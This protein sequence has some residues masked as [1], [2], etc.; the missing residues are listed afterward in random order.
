LDTNA[1][2]FGVGEAGTPS[3][4]FSFD[5]QLHPT[6]IEITSFMPPLK[7][8]GAPG[9]LSGKITDTSTNT[10]QASTPVDGLVIETRG[11]GSDGLPFRV[12]SA[13]GG[14]VSFVGTTV[15]RTEP[16]PG[17]DAVMAFDGTVSYIRSSNTDTY[18]TIPHTSKLTL[19]NIL[20][21]NVETDVTLSGILEDTAFSSEPLP[22]QTISFGVVPEIGPGFTIDPVT[23]AFPITVTTLDNVD[24][25][26]V[27]SSNT[28]HLKEGDKLTLPL[29]A[30]RATLDIDDFGSSS[31]KVRIFWTCT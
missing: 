15:L 10:P 31:V 2:Y 26:F 20:D 4:S 21:V 1:D 23:T 5:S 22:G 19:D 7:P 27:D 6:D 8:W 29:S 9:T 28:L 25:V 12:E 13:G 18:I 16:S 3:A 11:T 14:L 30:P 24:N 17:V